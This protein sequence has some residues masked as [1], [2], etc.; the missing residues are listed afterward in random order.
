M[1]HPSEHHSVTRHLSESEAEAL[2]ESVRAFGSA[3]RLRML[4][5][6]IDGELRVEEIAERSGMSPSAVSHQ[7]RLLRQHR[8]VVVRRSGR[9]AYYRLHDHHVPE[10]LAA[11][12]HHHEHLHPEYAEVA[13]GEAVEARPE[14]EAR[15]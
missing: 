3:S 14:A 11:L 10:I 9:H 6:L 12:R 5:M 2:A 15:R 1:P 13:G 7:L 8:L 4:W